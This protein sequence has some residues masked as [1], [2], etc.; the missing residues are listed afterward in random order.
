MEHAA[1][2]RLFRDEHAILL[3]LHQVVGIRSVVIGRDVLA[4]ASRKPQD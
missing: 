2:N 4:R 3:D 1:P